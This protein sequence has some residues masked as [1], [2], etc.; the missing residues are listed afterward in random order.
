MD[1]EILHAYRTA[2]RL[3]SPASFKNGQALAMLA[4]PIGKSSP[5]MARSRDKRRITKEQLA[6]QVRKTFND[7]AVVENDTVL[8][9]MYKLRNKG[10]HS[11]AF[12]CY[13]WTNSLPIDKTFRLKFPA[14]KSKQ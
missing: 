6:T 10:T 2:Y 14:I 4:S 13:A 5:T 3:S 1:R 12:A 11:L 7:M 9:V 8:D